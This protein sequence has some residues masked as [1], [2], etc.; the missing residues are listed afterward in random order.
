MSLDQLIECLPHRPPFLFVSSIEKHEPGHVRGSWRV[1]GE[2][3]FLEGHFPKRPLVPGVLLTEALAQVGGLTVEHHDQA[4]GHLEG[5]SADSKEAEQ[6]VA[7]P[8]GK[9]QSDQHRECAAP[10]DCPVLTFIPSREGQIDRQI[11]D[12]FGNGENSDRCM[13]QR[14]RQ[15]S[16]RTEAKI[17]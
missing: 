15:V 14:H 6:V 10:G 3:W 16:G 9:K 2:E 1:T 12:L 7:Q 17:S 8:G 5:W 11:A 13:Q 4:T